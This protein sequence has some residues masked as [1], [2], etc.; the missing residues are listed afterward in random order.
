MS[1]NIDNDRFNFFLTVF[2]AAVLAGASIPL[3]SVMDTTNN[4]LSEVDEIALGENS[5]S[6]YSGCH[7]LDMA[8][9]SDQID[10]IRVA[11]MSTERPTT[12]DF[13]SSSIE[14]I[15]GELNRVEIVDLEEG[16]Y[17]ADSV[18][19]TGFLSEK[20]VDSRPSDAVALS[21][22]TDSYIFVDNQL[23]RSEGTYYCS[24]DGLSI[25]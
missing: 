7:R 5:I 2:M 15:G 8:V 6:L 25:I 13:F 3:L 18:Y 16:A 21:Q 17:L 12:M 4:T 23:L 10:N 9:S 22:H 19:D 20:R 24:T 14:S 11:Q 1:K